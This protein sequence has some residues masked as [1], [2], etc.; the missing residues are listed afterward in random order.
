MTAIERVRKRNAA[1]EQLKE[2]GIYS[3][4]DKS[5]NLIVLYIPHTPGKDCK[6]VGFMTTEG[7]IAMY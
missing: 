5:R 7:E 1:R 3:N 4:W 6:E 2:L